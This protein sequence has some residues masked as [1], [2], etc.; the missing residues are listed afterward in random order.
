MSWNEELYSIYEN[1]CHRDFTDEEYVMLPVSHST[2]NAQIEIIINH[3]GEFRGARTVEK[4]EARTIIPATEDSASRSSGICPMPYA[5]KLKY[6]AGDYAEYNVGKNADNAGFY[7]AYMNQLRKWLE[8]EHS[9]SSVSAL[10]AYLD[11]KTVM[12]DLINS[13]V[14]QIDSATKKLDSKIKIAGISQE[15]AFVRFIINYPDG[16][17]KTWEDHTLSDSFILFNS[18]LLGEKQ[19]CYGSGEIVPVT[20][21]HPAKIRNTGD[22]AKLISSNDESGFTYRGRFSC[23]EEALSV[24]YNYSQKIHNAL[25][26][27]AEKQ[28]IRFDSLTLIIWASGLQE[29]EDIFPLN[30]KKEDDPF[31]DDESE[32]ITVPST[33]PLYTSLVKKRILLKGEKLPENSK[34]MIMGLDAA[35]TGRMNISMY[36]EFYKS[37]FLNNIENWHLSTA[38]TRYNAKKNVREISS[39]SICEIIKYAFGNDR[40]TAYMDCDNKILRENILRIIP[41]VT[42]GKKIPESIFR[43]LCCKASSPLSFEHGYNHNVVLEIVCSIIRKQWIDNKRGDIS[44]SYDPNLKDRSYLY[45]C[46][47]AIADMAEKDTYENEDKKSRV[48]NARRYWNTFSQRPCSTWQTIRD[49][50]EPYFTKL[51]SRKYER[52]EKYEEYIRDI[53]NKMTPDMFTDNSRLG[54]LYLLG[55]Y[56]FIQYI[57]DG[58]KNKEEN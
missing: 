18:S 7:I 45:G 57:Y 44:M 21:K 3:E 54:P 16:V 30:Q 17:S 24:G 1:N 42:Q 53:K 5:D 12:I 27:L 33:M 14:I 6:I 20:Y 28:G 32:E 9:H 19:L 31:S 2:A 50:L 23:K 15:D 4:E 10:Y 29:V 43:Q 26:W 56:N 51:K 41:C 58:F 48:T 34:I 39:L 35:T 22:K 36:S 40:S 52:C 11:K 37:D 46:L 47:L 25:R 55:Y 8:S 13:G 49:R 38:W